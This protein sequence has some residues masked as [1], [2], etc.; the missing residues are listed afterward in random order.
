MAD[1]VAQGLESH[2]RWRRTFAVG[3]PVVIG[4]AAGPWTVPWDPQI[5]RQHAQLTWLDS[6]LRVEQLPTARNA[7]FFQGKPVANCTLVIGEHIVIGETT[8]TLVDDQIN[9]SLDLPQPLREQTFSPQYLKRLRYRNADERI[10]ILSRLPEVISGA[11]NEAELF[12]R[13]VNMLLAGIP[14]AGAVA[15]VT[16]DKSGATAPLRVLQWD[17]RLM[18][19]APFQPSEP[20]IREAIRRRESVLHVWSERL[21]PRSQAFTA[22]ENTDWA[23]CTPV[24]GEACA[25]WAIYIAGRFAA[26]ANVTPS[27]SDPEDLRDD[28]KFTEL[29]AA[30][31]SSL[32]EARLLERQQASLRQ[33]FSPV[34]LEALSEGEPEQVL[35]PREAEV[36]VLFCDLRGFS[37]KSEQAAGDLLGLLQ[38]V[39]KA[40][41]VMTRQI[42]DHGGV[43]GDFQGDA[44]MGFWGWPLNSDDAMVRACQAALGIRAEFEAAARLPE[45]PLADFRMGIGLATGRAVAG[46]IGTT[47]QVKVTVFGP[48][49]NLASRLEEMTKILRAPILLDET[50][51]RNV[52]RKLPRTL[53]RCRRVAR[54]KPYGL[55]R[56][57]EVSELLPPQQDAA[58]LTDQN[59]AD[60]EAALDALLARQWSDALKLLH[61]VPAEDSVKDF[62]TVFIA[63]HNRTPPAAWDGVIP[64]LTKG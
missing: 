30:T 36:S 14:R 61:R 4:R 43:V 62:L 3:K 46:K 38:R 52:R 64:L 41:G 16:A 63:Q 50:T 26:G 29:V 55:D 31:L 53:G 9:V 32:R 21:D 2:Q 58:D 60:Y 19:G 57:L 23:F 49:V 17:R 12:S 8:F 51:A 5:S 40:L 44:A 35:Q 42:L 34:V 11:A 22:V 6:G 37:L 54:V 59:L 28:L 7:I 56:A 25:G 18:I 15:L 33:F 39:S 45:H 10:E 48:V 1:L 47:D 13:M 20:L 24:L 27:A